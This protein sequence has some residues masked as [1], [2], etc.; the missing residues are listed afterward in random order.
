MILKPARALR[1]R[2]QRSGNERGLGPSLPRS[3]RLWAL[4]LAKSESRGPL[5]QRIITTACSLLIIQLSS[6]SGGMGEG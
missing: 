1:I 2:I 3:L 6:L 4:P 5:L